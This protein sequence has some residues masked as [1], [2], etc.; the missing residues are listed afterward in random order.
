MSV[1]KKAGKG[2]VSIFYRNMLEKLV[3]MAAMVILARK[4]TPYDFGLVSITE[5]LLYLLSSFGTT[6][7]AEYLL[8]YRKDDSE[9]IF[10]SAFWFNIII[11]LGICL[12]FLIAVPFWTDFQSDDRIWKI[13]LLLMGGFVFSQLQLIPKT[14]LSRN[15][16][17]DKQ[18]KIQAPFI[19]LVA[20]GKIAAVYLNFGVY[21]LIIPTL[22]FQPIITL[23]LYRAAGFQPG[24]QLYVS[25][26]KEIYRFTRY[27]IG[28]GILSRL[29]DQGDKIILGKML[30]L[31]MLGIYNIAVQ[32]SDLVTSQL[33]TVSNNILS[34]VLPKYVDDKVK[35][36]NYYITFLKTFAFAVLPVLSI[37]L[38]NAKPI[39]LLLYGKQWA[40][41]AL[42]M[43]ILI[44]YAA[45][46]AL[47][48]SY[49][50]V[51]NSF[52]LNKTSFKTTVAYTPFHIVGSFIGASFG[53]AGLATSITTVRLLFTNIGIR[54]TMQAVSMPMIKWYQDLFPYLLG[55]VITL[56][57]ALVMQNA[58]QFTTLPLLSIAINAVLFLAGY[59]LFYKL[60][61]RRELE[62]ISAFLDSIFP[63]S[64]KVFNYL[65]GI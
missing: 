63:K 33:V 30:G 13:G 49:G 2:F 25:R 43:Q 23:L 53:I 20:A 47:T 60:F 19:L 6:G 3:G 56:V 26:W 52:H 28:S 40:A 62:I 31:E 18:V 65:F 32:L 38:V 58:P 42:P 50:C 64:R 14:W 59:Y 34:S 16:M 27:L 22:L 44:V 51:M 1:G 24:F 61:F 39:I 55:F 21:S 7:L 15:L 12:L 45:F 29:A 11:T 10:K 8:A 4:L 41:A 9:E 54:Q 48:S 35:F 36:Y 46:R 17:F 5:A 37:M 57:L